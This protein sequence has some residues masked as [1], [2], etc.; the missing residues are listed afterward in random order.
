[1]QDDHPSPLLAIY[2]GIAGVF[3]PS[4]SL[5]ESV[6]GRSPEEDGHSEYEAAP[7]VQQLLKDW[8]SARIILTSTLP[9][10]DGLSSVLFNLG[11]EVASRVLGFTYADLTAKAQ[12][13]PRDQ[14]LGN[15]DYWRHVKAEIVRLHVGWA[16]P[17]AWIAVD[18]ETL[19]WSEEERRQHFVQVDGLKGLLDPVAQ[20]Q[21]LT[22]LAGNF[23]PPQPRSA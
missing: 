23:G 1:M 9:W 17:A 15:A 4:R 19:L 12:L 6:F 22:K 2:L 14:P 11:P 3:H 21:L 5:Y 10:R 16:K 13:G 7:V 8:P 20:D 18:D